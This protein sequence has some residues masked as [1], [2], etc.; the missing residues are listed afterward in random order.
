MVLNKAQSMA[1]LN[2]ILFHVFGLPDDDPLILAIKVDEGIVDVNDFMG[3][4]L[5]KIKSLKYT[6]PDGPNKGKQESVLRSKS[7]MVSVFYDFVCYRADKQNPIKDNWIQITQEEFDEFRSS[8]DY[9]KARPG[10]T[11]TADFTLLGPPSNAQVVQPASG[12]TATQSCTAASSSTLLPEELFIEEHKED[13]SSFP[14]L[15]DEHL[16]QSWHHLVELELYRMDSLYGMDMS[17]ILDPYHI[18]WTPKEQ[19][20]FKIVQAFMYQIL[21]AKVLTPEGQKIVKKYEESKNAQAAYA[22]LVKYHK[23]LAPVSIPIAKDDLDPLSSMHTCDAHNN[24]SEV[25]SEEVVEQVVSP[26]SSECHFIVQHVPEDQ[27]VGSVDTIQ[28]IIFHEQQMCEIKFQGPGDSMDALVRELSWSDLWNTELY[29]EEREYSTVPAC[30]EFPSSNILMTPL[31]AKMNDRIPPARCSPCECLGSTIQMEHLAKKQKLQTDGQNYQD[32]N[33]PEEKRDCVCQGYDVPEEVEPPDPPWNKQIAPDP[34]WNKQIAPDPPWNKQIAFS[35]ILIKEE[36][37]DN[38]LENAKRASQDEDNVRFRGAPIKLVSDCAKLEICIMD[39]SGAPAKTW[40]QFPAPDDLNLRIDPDGGETS[41]SGTPLI[42]SKFFDDGL[43]DSDP[44]NPNAQAEPQDDGEHIA[45]RHSINSNA[46]DKYP[47]DGERVSPPM[48]VLVSPEDLVGRTLL[49]DP[50]PDGQR[51]CT[52]IIEMIDK[53][54]NELNKDPEQL[55]FFCKMDQDGREELLTYHQILDHLDRNAENPV[56]WKYKCIIS[57]Q[58]V[59]K[60]GD[61]DNNGSTCNVMPTQE[62]GKITTEHLK[63][64]GKYDL[65]ACAIY[66]KED[67]FLT[68]LLDLETNKVLLR[69]IQALLQM[70]N[71]SSHGSEVLSM[72]KQSG[73]KVIIFDPGGHTMQANDSNNCQDFVTLNWGDRQVTI[74]IDA[75]NCGLLAMHTFVGQTIDLRATLRCIGVPVQDEN[76]T[77][78]DGDSMVMDYTKVHAKLCNHHDIISFYFVREAVAAGYIHSTHTLGSTNPA[79]ILSKHLGYSDA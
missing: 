71:D 17:G 27:T 58:G 57:H 18:P 14:E 52:N 13:Q 44:I 35:D 68:R 54:N 76:Y 22:E 64:V 43:A 40:L 79:D 48:D 63:V 33:P 66:A 50:E 24:V 30:K 47:D 67:N 39:K 49:M 5:T 34:P 21:K 74:K 7:R 3:L 61:K 36:N 19:Q 75:C 77:F 16:H 9:L 65:V 59:L 31:K 20:E 69:F 25:G 46:Q 12:S 15:L 6:I 37:L 29:E 1:A 26:Q 56:V 38:I 78:C 55:K 73:F 2:H 23:T 72:R 41:P 45:D 60:P 53:H 8:V 70:S 42:K 32:C 51:F 4:T 11:E 62:G 10:Y 28:K